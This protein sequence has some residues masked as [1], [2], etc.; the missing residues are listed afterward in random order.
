MRSRVGFSIGA[1]KTWTRD[2]A[3]VQIIHLHS[4]WKPPAFCFY[5]KFVKKLF[6]VTILRIALI[7]DYPQS[8]RNQT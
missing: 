8:N 4:Q 6:F 7:C 1:R 2:L 5:V 3:V